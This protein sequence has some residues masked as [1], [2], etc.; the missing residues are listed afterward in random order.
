MALI[1]CS[2]AEGPRGPKGER[3]SQGPAGPGGAGSEDDDGS[4]GSS[5]DS[6]GGAPKPGDSSALPYGDG[7]AG[8]KVVT[9]SGLLSDANLQYASFTVNSGVELQV[10]S[11]TVL[12]IK[13]PFTNEGTITVMPG[14]AGGLVAAIT[15]QGQPQIVVPADPGV[16]FTPPQIG[17][18]APPKGPAAGGM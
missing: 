9:T 1:A 12:R 17:S 11:G 16:S 2:G 13:G 14:T 8:A 5:G 6:G 4:H 18:F 3:G 7:S 15:A 10:A